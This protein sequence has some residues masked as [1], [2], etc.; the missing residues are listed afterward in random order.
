MNNKKNK[1]PQIQ[2]AARQLE[3]PVSKPNNITENLE[4]NR[5]LVYEYTI[6]NLGIHHNSNFELYISYTLINFGNIIINLGIHHN[7]LWY[8]L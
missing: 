1:D 7:Y 3:I 8:M 4:Q 5:I 6:I 2:Y